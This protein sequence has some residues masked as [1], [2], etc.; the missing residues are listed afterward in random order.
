MMMG[1]RAYLW[2]SQYCNVEQIDSGLSCT[3]GTVK[4]GVQTNPISSLIV[5]VALIF[6]GYVIYI[7]FYKKKKLFGKY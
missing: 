4:N 2:L 1:A 5:L 6:A 7:K 3:A